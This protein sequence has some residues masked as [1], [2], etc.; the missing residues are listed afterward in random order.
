MEFDLRIS[1]QNLV[2]FIWSFE[3]WEIIADCQYSLG[4]S[5]SNLETT[6][7]SEFEL[8]GNLLSNIW[9][10]EPTSIRESKSI[11]F[12]ICIACMNFLLAHYLELF[13][14]WE[15]LPSSSISL[16]DVLF[17][18]KV[19]HAL[20]DLSLFHSILHSTQEPTGVVFQ[21]GVWIAQKV[22]FQVTAWVETILKYGMNIPKQISWVIMAVESLI[23]VFF[24]KAESN[25]LSQ[26]CLIL[27]NDL[28]W[29][30]FSSNRV[31]E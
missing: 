26:V 25:K 23:I 8:F 5:K 30:L 1:K 22:I 11:S 17:C 28:I 21:L 14:G 2:V 18:F 6:H 10:N 15:T 19:T 27:S 31:V 16:E 20:Y 4:S 3:F 7:I 12:N 13:G 29:F 24:D 9:S